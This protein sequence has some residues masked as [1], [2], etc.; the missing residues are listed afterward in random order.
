MFGSDFDR[1]G[2]L[3]RSNYNIGIGHNYGFLKKDPFGGELTS[4]IPRQRRIPR[5]NRPLQRPQLHLDSGKL[6]QSEQ[7]G[8]RSLVHH[9]RHRLYRE[10]VIA[11]AHLAARLPLKIARST[12]SASAW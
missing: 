4:A 9:H 1:P 2:L 3:P 11:A 5:R 8:H 12:A 7:S 10:L 6:Q